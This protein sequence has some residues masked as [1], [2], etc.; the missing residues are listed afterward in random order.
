MAPNQVAASVTT[1]RTTMSSS[2]ALSIENPA[3][4]TSKSVTSDA[5]DAFG[6]MPSERHGS[7]VAVRNALHQAFKRSWS[8]PARSAA[9][10]GTWASGLSL[11]SHDGN[12]RRIEQRDVD[13]VECHALVEQVRQRVFERER[14]DRRVGQRCAGEDRVPTARVRERDVGQR[15]RLA[16]ERLADE[17]LADERQ[18]DR[19][20]TDERLADERLDG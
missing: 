14:V 2:G 3:M 15:D 10:S 18:I 13:L 11:S 17:R 5:G 4:L 9:V 12:G 7:C 16:D 8:V 20:L 1:S 19:R 6:S